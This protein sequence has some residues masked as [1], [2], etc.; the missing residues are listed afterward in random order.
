MTIVICIEIA[1]GVGGIGDRALPSDVSSLVST[2][3]ESGSPVA[4][5]VRARPQAIW[6]LRAICMPARPTR[7]RVAITLSKRAI[8]QARNRRQR[9]CA[10]G[11]GVMKV[12]L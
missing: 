7:R 11:S 1:L 5:A 12:E 4:E 9:A 8:E 2:R 3:L 6:K 10:G